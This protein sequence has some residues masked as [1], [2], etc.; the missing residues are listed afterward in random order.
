MKKLTKIITSAVLTLGL[1]ACGSSSSSAASSASTASSAS[2]TTGGT[3][4]VI[5]TANPH[6]VIL[7]QAK[8]IL[9]DKYNIDLDIEVTDDYY[10]PNEAV[11]NGDADANYF[12][13]VPFFDNEKETNNYKI[14][15]AGYIH[16]EPFGIYSKNIKSVDDIKDG[17]TII[18]SNSVADNGRI[19][20]L[21]A[22]DNLVKLPDDAD[23]LKI[24][25]QDIDNDENNP[26]HFVFQEV[27]PE[28]LATSY[29]NNPD[30]LVAINGNYAIQAGLKPGS[31]ALILEDAS[32][33]NPYVNIVACQ[34]GHENDP[35]I[36]A[37]VEVLK[38]DEI[39]TFIKK[40]WSDGSVI[41]VTD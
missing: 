34:E 41:P 31:D 5:A 17:S 12:Q 7:E 38:S 32:E 20:A 29:E 40:N 4:K 25:I 36:K 26:H 2:G 8:P 35:N 18:I 33:D 10:I 15:I 19:L 9:K 23:V 39:T 16:I 11:S 13:H 22:Q 1:T 28:L 14:A 21:L 3:L 30:A 6:A 27:K 37:L 24:T